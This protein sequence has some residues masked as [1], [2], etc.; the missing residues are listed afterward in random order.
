MTGSTDLTAYALPDLTYDFSAAEDLA[1]E[2]DL[3]KTTVQL[4]APSRAALV[5]QASADFAGGFAETFRANA[6][7]AQE[8]AREL[9]TKLGETA[10]GIRALSDAAREENTRRRTARAWRDR[11]L[12]RRADLVDSTW[13]AIFGEEPPPSSG[14]VDV[15]A[16]PI[17]AYKA[18]A[19]STPAPGSAPGSG[20]GVSSARPEDLRSFASGSAG[21]NGALRDVPGRIER[22]LAAFTQRCDFG[23][24]DLSQLLTGFRAWTTANDGDVSWANTIAAAFEAAGARGDVVSLDDS[25]LAAALS[26]A[27]VTRARSDLD[28]GAPSLLGAVPTSGFAADPVNTATGNFVEHEHDLAFAGAAEGFG[29]ARTYN[30]FDV[31]GG[32]FGPGWSSVLDQ[33]LEIHADHVELV[34]ADGRRSTFPIRGDT[35]ARAVGENLWL[36]PGGHPAD[37]STDGTAILVVRDNAGSWRSFSPDGV[38]LAAGTGA[39]ATVTAERDRDGALVR[40]RHRRGRFVD[41]RHVDGLVRSARSSDGRVVTYEYGGHR[42]LTSVTGPGGTRTYTWDDD[43]RIERVTAADGIVECANTYDE[44]GRVLLQTTPHGRTVRFAYLPGRVTSVADEDGAN[45]N[46]WLSDRNGRVVA[47]TDSDGRRQSLSHDEHGNLVASTARDGSVTVHVYDDRGRLVRTVT[48]DGTDTTVHHDDHDR[49]RRIE[50]DGRTVSFEYAEPSAVSPSAVV[51][52]R[53]GRF[54]MTWVDDLL[55]RVEDPEGVVLTFQHDHSGDLVAVQDAFG[56]TTRHT[57]DAAG[58]IVSTTTPMGHRTRYERD[59][60]GRVTSREDPDGSV[61]RFEHDAGGR[62]VVVEDPVGGRTVREYG[63]NGFL[64][65]TADPLGRTT[66]VRYDRLGNLDEVVLPDGTRWELLHDALSRLREVVDAA[67]ERWLRE[68]DA[69]GR[70][71]VR[72]DPTGVRSIVERVGAPAAEPSFELDLAGRVAGATS[73]IGDRTTIEYDAC[74]RVAAWTDADGGRTA[75]RY[76]AD[77]RVVERIEPMGTVTAFEYDACSRLVEER[78]PGLGTTRYGYDAV[79]RLT[80]VDD[81]R[82]GRRTITRDLAGQVVAVDDALGHSTTFA[83]DACGEVVRTVGP[84]GGCTLTTRTQLGDVAS[85]VDPMGRTVESSWDP[86]GRL[87]SR[88]DPD[89]H[90]TT[91]AHDTAGR[92]SAVRCDGR[93]V[94]AVTRDESDRSVTV[95]DMTH[96]DGEQTVHRLEYGPGN[97]LLRRTTTRAGASRTTSW[98]Y[99]AAGNQRAVTTPDGVRTEYDRGRAG[100]VTGIRRPD[101]PD[102]SLRHDGDGRLTEVVAGPVAQSWRHVDGFVVGHSADGRATTLERDR[103]GRITALHTPDGE[104]VTYQYDEASQLI[105]ASGTSVTTWTYDDAGRLVD[106]R[107]ASGLTSYAHDASGALLQVDRRGDESDVVR[108]EYDG[109]GRRIRATSDDD[110]T[111]YE[112]DERGHLRSVVRHDGTATERSDLWVNALGELAEVDGTTLCWD[113]TAPVPTLLSIGDVP[114]ITAP[115]LLGV[116]GT[117][118][119][120]GWRPARSAEL[121]DPWSSTEAVTSPRIPEGIGVSATGSVMVAGLELTGARVYDPSVRSFLSTDPLPPVTGAAWA[122]NPYAFA[123]N[124]PVN[125]TDPT[126]LRPIT[127]AE[128]AAYGAGRQGLLGISYHLSNNSAFSMDG[129]LHAS[130]ALSWLLGM[131]LLDPRRPGPGVILGALSPLPFVGIPVG[132][133]A[134][135]YAGTVLTSG[136]GEMLFGWATG[137]SPRTLLYGSDSKMTQVVKNE[138]PDDQRR[139]ILDDLKQDGVATGYGYEAG[140]ASLTNQNLLR[141]LRTVVTWPVASERDRTLLALGTYDVD[142]KVVSKGDDGTAVVEYTA[143]NETTLGSALRIPGL[144]YG[145]LNRAAGDHGPFSRVTEE[146]TWTEKVKW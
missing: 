144:D 48:P 28:F 119:S 138:L 132:M 123:G 50:R 98:E 40:L 16:F 55:V 59:D 7:I 93:L 24:V 49:V 54:S 91:W 124:D 74:G 62:V 8:D 109:C 82:N 29:L 115:G 134:D 80:S 90:I 22:A 66:T 143:T 106:E 95:T 70:P 110:T 108:F 4:Q 32:V 34:H 12:A 39:V 1:H 79:G 17:T 10:S 75:L 44:H 35:A 26:A 105:G 20:G 102:V 120:S 140:P 136:Q 63:S 64:A 121:H 104:V 45:A 126:G 67:G 38:W 99:D 113:P 18:R 9:A 15:P 27:G 53:G 112:W 118:T 100:L 116:D 36:T 46:T 127:D 69:V 43:G 117:W 96:P 128:L 41:L 21:L 73:P 19:R 5:T 146:F 33:R 141:D 86:A 97:E 65:R 130:H 114:I 133:A 25:S 85:R 13:D 129:D 139:D 94:A 92:L 72:T 122:D 107:G 61:W 37:P 71:T 142:A 11:V 68:Y 60:E 31:V 6:A 103:R 84:S 131:S 51:G 30:S 56:G 88:S 47:I 78:V 52:E 42:A 89:G 14:K 145:A 111:S 77:S 81:P 83:R 137:T 57:R 76:D 58:R 87:T 23:H 101:F 2:C 3:A 125:Q 135:F